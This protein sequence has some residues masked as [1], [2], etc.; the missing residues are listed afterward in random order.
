MQYDTYSC[1]ADYVGG[2]K[3][4][5]KRKLHENRGKSAYE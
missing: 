2:T 1:L 5:L 4:H 3:L